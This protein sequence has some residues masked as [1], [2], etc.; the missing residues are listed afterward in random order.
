MMLLWGKPGEKNEFLPSPLP[1]KRR[2]RDIKK[3]FLIFLCKLIN[4]N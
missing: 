4:L 3:L 1:V 2:F